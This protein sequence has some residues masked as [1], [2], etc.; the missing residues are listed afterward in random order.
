[1]K[2]KLKYIQ[3]ASTV[4]IIQC[5]LLIVNIKVEGQVVKKIINNSYSEIEYDKRYLDYSRFTF[6]FNNVMYAPA[7]AKKTEGIYDIDTKPMRGMNFGVHYSFRRERQLS[8]YTGLDMDFIPFLYYY[9]ELPTSEYPTG[10]QSYGRRYE[11]WINEHNVLTVPFGAVWKSPIN[12]GKYSTFNY[13]LS[14]DIRFHIIQPGEMSYSIQPGGISIFYLYG[15]TRTIN[16]LSPTINLSA[17]IDWLTRFAIINVNINLQKGIV[18]YLRGEYFF[19]NLR[20]SPDTKGIYKVRA[21]Y[22]GI[23]IGI[24][25][26][27]FRRKI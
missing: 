12:A 15:K 22:L 8:Y 5:L 9:Y 21:D 6:H 10:F 18:P 14:A 16:I 20:V 17:G 19:H 2:V 23:D 3:E 1:M 11:K 27:K 24:T 13:R 4:L 25:P 7:Y 26:K